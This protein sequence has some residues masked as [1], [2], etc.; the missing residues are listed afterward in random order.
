LVAATQTAALEHGAPISSR[1][2]L[3]ESMH[4]HAAAD[5][6]LVRTFRHSSF[7]ALKIIA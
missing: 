2:A 5:L 6:R 7:L 1:H 3:A 4:A